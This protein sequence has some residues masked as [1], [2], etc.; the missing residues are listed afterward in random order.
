MTVITVERLKEAKSFIKSGGNCD[1]VTIEGALQITAEAV[2]W[3]VENHWQA[4][5]VETF[6]CTGVAVALYPCE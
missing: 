5:V 4:R 2:Q 3:L 6:G 1:A